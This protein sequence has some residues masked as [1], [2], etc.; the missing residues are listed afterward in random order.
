MPHTN[1]QMK[2]EKEN[3]QLIILIEEQ[4]QPDINRE[5]SNYANKTGK[6]SN[7]STVL[8][9]HAPVH[10]GIPSTLRKQH[11]CHQLEYRN[12]MSICH[13]CDSNQTPSYV[14]MIQA[15]TTAKMHSFLILYCC[16]FDSTLQGGSRGDLSQIQRHITRALEA[17]YYPPGHGS[18]KLT[19]FN[20]NNG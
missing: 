4:T 1:L 5:H 16:K 14:I 11:L 7:N 19:E 6:R 13:C 2:H 20:G 17:I 18:N 12:K 3:N 8:F 15:R 9:I 10:A